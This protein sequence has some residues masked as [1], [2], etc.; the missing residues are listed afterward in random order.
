MHRRKAKN[1][2]RISLND[3]VDRV[4]TEI[5]HAIEDDDISAFHGTPYLCL[6]TEQGDTVPHATDALEVS[7]NCSLISQNPKA[8]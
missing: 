4:I 6:I 1:L 8:N 5:T 2:F 7:S 3:E